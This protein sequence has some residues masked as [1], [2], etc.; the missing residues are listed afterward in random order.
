[1]SILINLAMFPTDKGDSVSQYVSKVVNHIKNSG[2]N[3][4]LN[5]MG[6]SIET[7]T[8]AEALSLVQQCYDILE[9]LSKR[10]Y[11]TISIDAQEGKSNRLES[12]VTSIEE[13]IGAVNK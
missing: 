1:M 8:M 11:C 3:Y 4:K 13:K 5:A 10:I 9:P 7:E 12:K 6:T 2:V